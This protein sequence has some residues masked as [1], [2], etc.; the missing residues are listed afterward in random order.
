MM[1]VV[2]PSAVE[3]DEFNQAMRASQ[4]GV[5]HFI[6]KEKKYKRLIGDN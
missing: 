4:V 6:L 5:L 1:V 2:V 3:K